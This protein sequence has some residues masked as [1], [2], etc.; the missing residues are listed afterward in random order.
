MT[1]EPTTPERQAPER[2]TQR[3]GRTFRVRL[4]RW[5][6]NACAHCKYRDDVPE[7][8]RFVEVFAP[9][10]SRLPPDLRAGDT[11]VLHGPE[12][13][14]QP[15][16]VPTVKR[17]RAVG[18]DV[19]LYTTGRPFVER[20][21]AVRLRRAGVRRFIVPV[22]GADAARHDRVAG[23]PGAF[24]ETRAGVANLLSLPNVD[25][26]L[27]VLVVPREAATVP[28]TVAAWR[29]AAPG[30]RVRLV[31]LLP[32][33]GA[34]RHPEWFEGQTGAVAAALRPLFAADPNLTATYFGDRRYPWIAAHLEDARSR[35]ERFER[36]Q[37]VD[38]A[39]AGPRCLTCAHDAV[40]S[41]FV[42]RR[43]QQFDTY[44]LTVEAPCGLACGFCQRRFT[45]LAGREEPVEPILER[46]RRD[47]VDGARS[48]GRHIGR[49]RINGADPLNHPRLLD[50]LAAV[51]DAGVRELHL[52]TPGL[53]FD[54]PEFT[55]AVFAALDRFEATVFPPIYGPD[56]ATHDAIMGAPGT[57]DRL[58]GAMTVLQ[59]YRDRVRFTTLVLR[60][61]A[62]TLAELHEFVTGQGFQLEPARFVRPFSDDPADYAAVAPRMRDV[63]AHYHAAGHEEVRHFLGLF[64]FV[65]CTYWDLYPSREGLASVEIDA[66]SYD[67]TGILRS[68]DQFRLKRDQVS[69]CD[70]PECAVYDRCLNQVQYFRVHGFSEFRPLNADGTFR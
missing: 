37:K 8:A 13:A 66:G 4:G 25:V 69:H 15:A 49:V 32:V 54:D 16:F 61:N 52:F 39:C 70:R 34:A 24:A 59:P 53:R 21:A 9:V 63:I 2:P 6:P 45:D 26:R 47:V 29:A 18:A 1:P 65:P 62:T 60:E 31:H 12:P 56:A 22:F 44:N 35:D 23:V 50:I 67:V 58:L 48:G 55:R 51:A 28:E 14:M 64:S 30:A 19:L 46:F 42:R 10:D 3:G 17:V 40:C 33:G 68:H 7:T 36:L 38:A 43:E 5:C 41:Y 11:V 57:F 27:D 20:R